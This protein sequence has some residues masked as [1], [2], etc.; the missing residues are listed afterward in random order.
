MEGLQKAIQK[1]LHSVENNHL[2][3]VCFSFTF[4]SIKNFG[5]VRYSNSRTFNLIRPH[6][7]AW[8]SA[9]PSTKEVI[10]VIE[11]LAET[12]SKMID[13][14]TLVEAAG[15]FSNVASMHAF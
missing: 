13:N 3:N 2:E 4:A 15:T 14:F 10:V 9:L 12:G 1:K 5:L 8:K 6:H 11:V 7:Q